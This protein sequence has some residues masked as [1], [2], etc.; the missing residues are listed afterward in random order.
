M[1]GR[2]KIEWSTL[3]S[4]FRNTQEY[5]NWGATG[6]SSFM[7]A[8]QTENNTNLEYLE[9]KIYTKYITGYKIIKKTL[10]SFK[11]Y[12]N[13]I[14]NIYNSF[15]DYQTKIKNEI[16]YNGSLEYK[17]VKE[18]L[19]NS[20]EVDTV[21]KEILTIQ[22]EFFKKKVFRKIKIMYY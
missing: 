17:K 5:I 15:D 3:I 22:T 21:I 8:I 12:K 18:N 6:D 16:L 20:R 13:N 9:T 14:D 19:L 1:D 10:E 2:K 4:E 7:E 11:Y